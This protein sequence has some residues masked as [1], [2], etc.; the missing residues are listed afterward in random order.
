MAQFQLFNGLTEPETTKP[1][2]VAGKGVF[3][4]RVQSVGHPEVLAPP[5]GLGLVSRAWLHRLPAAREE[6][7]RDPCFS[8]GAPHSH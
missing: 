3:P 1:T 6:I 8:H 7:S 5:L 2:G 4:S